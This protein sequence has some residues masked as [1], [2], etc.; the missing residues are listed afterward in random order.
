MRAAG[1]WAAAVNGAKM[2]L[3][4][5]RRQARGVLEKGLEIGGVRRLRFFSQGLL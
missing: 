1:T 3:P 4:A 5:R 2:D